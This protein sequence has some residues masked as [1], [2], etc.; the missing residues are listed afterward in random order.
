MELC[1]GNSPKREPDTGPSV[2]EPAADIRTDIPVRYM[3]IP[4]LLT[5]G[6]VSITLQLYRERRLASTSPVAVIDRVQ[7]ADLM[8][9]CRQHLGRLGV[10]DLS[11]V[12]I[13]R[14]S[15]MD[16][17]HQARSGRLPPAAKLV[18]TS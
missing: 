18:V 8:Y 16:R 14:F 1:T 7:A 11:T 9:K 15:L 10:G 12:P 6:R 4:R 3:L 2:M 13:D 5:D 17:V